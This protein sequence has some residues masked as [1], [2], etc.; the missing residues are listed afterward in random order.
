MN[1][2]VSV[3]VMTKMC[4]CY[5]FFFVLLTERLFVVSAKVRSVVRAYEKTTGGGKTSYD[6]LCVRH[7]VSVCVCCAGEV[8]S[9]ARK[10]CLEKSR[11][12]A[13]KTRGST[14]QRKK[15]R[16]QKWGLVL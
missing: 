1:E 14:R 7:I 9:R 11:R 12:A 5:F 10:P 15:T 13:E 2:V 16:A 8:D 4:C 6:L 3:I